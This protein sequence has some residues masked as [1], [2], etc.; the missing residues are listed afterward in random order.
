[1]PLELAIDNLK[2]SMELHDLR[3]FVAVAEELHFRHAAE[4]LHMTQPALSRQI[5]GLE[6]EL[7]VVLLQRTQR[8]V[9]LTMAGATFLAEAR[10]IL[11]RTEQAIQT[12][13]RVARGEVGQLKLSFVAPALRGVLPAMVRSFR[14]R[15]PDV[16]LILSERRTHEQVEAFRVHQIDLGVLYPP[17]DESWLQVMPI[18]TESWII[19]LPKQ[20]PLAQK[21]HLALADLAQEAFILYPRAEG[22][23]FY[24]RIL[25]LCEQAGFSPTI[26]QDAGVSQ[27]RVGL[28]A[29]GMG[30]TFVPS[31]LQMDADPD[32]AYRALKGTDLTLDI[33]IASRRDHCSPVVEQFLTL[34]K[35]DIIG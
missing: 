30:I 33:A 1:M 35:H 23:M 12:T 17:V 27:T 25:R 10:A 8:Q 29:I 20:H 19:A 34:V 7:G 22:P 5:R 16:Q 28:V 26:V 4:R 14:A 11:Q 18:A 13:Q 3:Y 21:Q 24:D 9:R 6:A 2:A 31:H 15:C 32:V